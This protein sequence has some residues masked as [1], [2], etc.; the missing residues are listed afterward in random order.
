MSISRMDRSVTERDLDRTAEIVRLPERERLKD[1]EVS[2][3][4]AVRPSQKETT[5]TRSPTV[6]PTS[7][8][9]PKRRQLP[10]I[11]RPGGTSKDKGRHLF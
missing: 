4:P 8:P 7:T 5:S 10:A 11:P 1:R 6:T 3:A 2:G 9:S